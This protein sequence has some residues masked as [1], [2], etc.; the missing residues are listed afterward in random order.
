MVETNTPSPLHDERISLPSR[1]FLE[2]VEQLSVAISI[3]DVQANILY[4]NPA[5]VLLTGYEAGELIGQN[6]SLLS[7]KRTPTAVYEDMWRTIRAGRTWSGMLVNRRKSGAPYLADLTVAPVTDDEGK[8]IYFLGMH[9]DV[10]AMHNLQKQVLNQKTLIESVLNSAPVAMALVDKR[11]KVILDNLAYKSLR[12]DLGGKEPASCVL[13]AWLSASG[14]DFKQAC[15]KEREFH[16]FEIRLDHSPGRGERW[17]SCSGSW[18]HELVLGPASYFEETERQAGLFLVCSEITEQRRQHELA[19]TNA[20]RALLAEQHLTQAMRETLWGALYQL[21]GPFNVIAAATDLFERQKDPDSPLLGALKQVL[22]SGREAMDR[23][24]AAVPAGSQE[25]VQPV[26]LNEAIRNVLGVM[27][28]RFLVQGVVVDWEPDKELLV[29]PGR[30]NA[31]QSLI[32]HLLDN[33]VDAVGEPGA[34]AREIHLRS[35]RLSDGRVE[36]VIEDRGP[37]VPAAFRL[38]AFEPFFSGW[39]AR[40]GGSGMG[41]ALAQEIVTEQGGSIEFDPEFSSGA[42]VRVLLTSTTGGD[43]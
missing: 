43:Q 33:A 2:A 17:F 25:A 37:G 24:R 40:R 31:L 8:V 41:L 23:L 5:C 7:D 30:L 6:E 38:K 29:V 14:V 22:H 34:K 10:T 19:R 28:H 9:R 21:Q 15:R 13:E 18:A 27:T 32:K 11:G 20:V 42:R 35:G 4:A 12:T 36:V 26:N 3:T 16:N 1:L 39:K